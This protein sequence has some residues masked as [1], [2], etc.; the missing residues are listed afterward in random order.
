VNGKNGKDDETIRDAERP[1][2]RREDRVREIQR[3]VRADRYDFEGKLA[4]ALSRLLK[5]VGD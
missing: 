5:D 1:S 4:A 2:P 3:L